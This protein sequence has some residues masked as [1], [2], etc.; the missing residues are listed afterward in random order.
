MNT[1]MSNEQRNKLNIKHLYDPK[2]GDYWD[3]R[4]IPIFIIIAVTPEKDAVYLVDMRGKKKVDV[5]ADVI[6]AD[7]D[8]FVKA[9]RYDYRDDV[10]PNDVTP[11]KYSELCTSW[12]NS[13][14]IYSDRRKSVL[15]KKGAYKEI[16]PG[17][18]WVVAD[19]QAIHDITGDSSCTSH[20]TTYPAVL[21]KETGGAWHVY[22][23]TSFIAEQCEEFKKEQTASIWGL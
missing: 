1:G 20:T 10:T 4:F 15:E 21:I 3:E 16:V 6:L 7:M 17:T 12:H 22:N 2:P 23:N 19:A 5:R 11:N 14:R 13:G 18:I 9:N 8:E